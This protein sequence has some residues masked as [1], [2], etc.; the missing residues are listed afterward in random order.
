MKKKCYE[1]KDNQIIL[2]NIEIF[3]DYH[4]KL[5]I[6]SLI[7]NDNYEIFIPVTINICLTN[8]KYL[9]DFIKYSKY[10]VDVL[11]EGFS[12]N[13]NNKYK[14]TEY[15]EEFFSIISNSKEYGKIIHNYINYKFDS[16]IRFYLNSIVYYNKNFEVEFTDVN[17]E[18]LIK[19]FYKQGFNI[20][21]EHKLNL[22]INIVKFNCMTLGVSTF[23]WNELIL[24]KSD[25]PMFI[26]IDY[27]T[28]HPDLSSSKFNNS[29]TVIHETGHIFGLKH[30]F[31][32]NPDSLNCYK[33]ILGQKFFNKIFIESNYDEKKI[34]TN[35][36]S[37]SNS[38]I[39]IPDNN[40]LYPDIIDQDE[41]TIKNPIEKKCFVLKDNIPINFACFMDYSPDEVLTHFTL[42]QCKI[43]RTIIYIYK[44]YL[45]KNSE[46]Y[47]KNNKK[48]VKL[49]LPKGYII[50]FKDKKYSPISTAFIDKEFIYKLSFKDGLSYSIYNNPKIIDK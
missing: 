6:D 31:N 12:G 47:Y 5:N 35:S 40:K 42:S 21:D 45:I 26:F 1:D 19:K 14:S 22:N 23:P 11:N 4:N 20:K 24:N 50:D 43:M 36:N 37:N 2:D 34:L 3:N 32:N 44:N 46:E 41:P 15:S 30:I 7:V 28:I 8:S 33:I 13:I 17:T 48:K 10:I 27:K 18:L 16:K 39:N 29:R 25:Y 38:K 9:I 49:Y